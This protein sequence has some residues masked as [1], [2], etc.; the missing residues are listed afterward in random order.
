MRYV[1]THRLIDTIN[2]WYK[3]STHDDKTHRKHHESLSNEG[4]KEALKWLKWRQIYVFFLRFFDD[5]Y[6]YQHLL[7]FTYHLITL[8]SHIIIPI[9][10]YQPFWSPFNEFNESNQKKLR[11]GDIRRGLTRINFKLPLRRLRKSKKSK[12]IS[13]SNVNPVESTLF[14]PNSTS[15]HDRLSLFPVDTQKSAMI[16]D[17]NV[18]HEIKVWFC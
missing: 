5:S 16:N 17:S 12:T 1:E 8:S 7:L 13:H 2:Q 3:Q 18:D 15:F 9:T 6:E 11:E 14:G 10:T 4:F